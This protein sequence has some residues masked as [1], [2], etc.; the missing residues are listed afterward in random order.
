MEKKL[1]YIGGRDEAALNALK[2][3]SQ[4]NGWKASVK[5]TAAADAREGYGVELS[6]K[7]PAGQS[8]SINIE[9]FPNVSLFDAQ[10]ALERTYEGYDTSYETYKRLDEEGHG[11][12]GAPYEII[13]VYKDMEACRNSIKELAG[14]LEK[15]MQRQ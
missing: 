3:I 14:I 7:S 2:E 10:E 5:N 12:N 6:R 9:L 11:K 1:H 4:K 13:D 8:F 15:G